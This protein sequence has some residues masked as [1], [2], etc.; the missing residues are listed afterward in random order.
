MSEKYK[1]D[2]PNGIYFVTLTIIQWINLFTR[3]EYVYEIV[4]SLKYC[5]NKKGLLIHGWVIMPSHLHLIISTKDE[6]LENIIRDFKKFTNKKIIDTISQINESRR[7]W[8]LNAFSKA[9]LQLKRIEGF[10]VWQD[11]SHPILLDSNELQEQKLAYV[12]RNPVEAEI[13][14]EAHHYKFSSAGD[15]AGIKGFLDI[16]FM[17]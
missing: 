5:Q 2:D 13:V 1:F 15:Y 17:D 3:K 12:H 16:E 14:I 6:R 9:A 7:Q 11:W 4:S 10:K 8:L